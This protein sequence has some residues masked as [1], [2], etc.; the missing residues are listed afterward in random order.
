MMKVHPRNKQ[1]KRHFFSFVRKSPSTASASSQEPTQTIDA[2]DDV[3]HQ[4]EAIEETE[5][6]CQGPSLKE[7]DGFLNALTR[8]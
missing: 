7:S 6:E 3:R 4:D 8:L 5:T 2:S 1:N